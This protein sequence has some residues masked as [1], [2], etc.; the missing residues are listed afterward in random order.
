MLTTKKLNSL[1]KGSILLLENNYYI[2]LSNYKLTEHQK[3]FLNLGL[4]CHLYNKCNQF[5]ILHENIEK[6][7]KQNQIKTHPAIKDIL[8]AEAIKTDMN[9]NKSSYLST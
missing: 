5:E 1:Y 7:Q 3:E 8:K 4:N 6:L 9:K 2:N